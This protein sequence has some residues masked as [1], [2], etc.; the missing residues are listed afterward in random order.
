MSSSNTGSSA[1]SSKKNKK[2]RHSTSH[3]EDDNTLTATTA[4]A[5]TELTSSSSSSIRV[6]VVESNPSHDPIVC[7]FP[8]GV[9]TNPL[10][11]QWY[12]KK[13]SKKS[14]HNKLDTASSV[15]YVL[16]GHDEACQYYGS[17]TS[18][19]SV[20]S[21]SSSHN[22]KLCVGIYDKETNVVTFYPTAGNGAVISLQQFVPSYHHSKE[23][24]LES[25]G[26]STKN[27][28]NISSSSNSNALLY[29]DFGS[30]K[31]RR[32]LQSQEAN[33]VTVDA[34][35]G[36]AT[37]T[38][39]DSTTTNTAFDHPAMSESNRSAIQHQQQ[40]NMALAATSTTS[41]LQQQSQTTTTS[42]I[43]LAAE[44]ATSHW[45]QTFLPP[46]DSLAT[47]ASQIYSVNAI[48]G[49]TVWNI[50][51]PNRIQTMQQ[52]RRGTTTTSSSSMIIQ[53]LNRKRHSHAT[54]SSKDDIVYCTDI[55]ADLLNTSS[56]YHTSSNNESPTSNFFKCT[57]LLNYFICVF[58]KFQQQKFR[59]PALIDTVENDDDDD[60]DIEMNDATNT[61][62]EPKANRSFRGKLYGSTPV[63]V[64][65]RFLELFT[66]SLSMSGGANNKGG[67]SNQQQQHTKCVMSRAQQDKCL[68]HIFV[69]YI[70]STTMMNRPRNKKNN[71]NNDDDNDKTIVI[72]DIMPLLNE[73]QLSDKI[74]HGILLLREA[75]CIVT[76]VSSQ[77]S[78][79]PQKKIKVELSVPLTFPKMKKKQRA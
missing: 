34:V 43:H 71:N 60:D 39:N 20:T 51:L 66:S 28:N 26:A 23:Q 5:T 13:N 24:N 44:L 55:V 11:F 77:S 10:T 53:Y 63:M 59:M 47:C 37:P 22:T 42:S 40:I 18:S 4:S 46:Y 74:N 32:V 9:P 76:R 78:S 35:V 69:L 29:A 68:V 49:P 33:R 19:S 70:L 8:G 65:Q 21:E 15:E 27:T 16:K 41:T 45:R 62:D 75:G 48:A 67:G 17:C 61:D 56:K 1:S 6:K 30:A 79:T 3:D 38:H 52:Q 57:L 14:S 58:H 25:N 7:S 73:L 54:K 50:T 2:K 64:L 72:H 36:D 31:K 12:Q